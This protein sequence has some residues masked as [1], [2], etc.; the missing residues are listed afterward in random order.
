MNPLALYLASGLYR[1]LDQPQKAAM[2]YAELIEDYP[3]NALSRK[4]VEEKAALPRT[5]GAETGA[6]P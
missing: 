6:T 5:A 4:A 3:D 2:L 1:K